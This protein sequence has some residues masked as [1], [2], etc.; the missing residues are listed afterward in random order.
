MTSEFDPEKIRLARDWKLLKQLGGEAFCFTGK[1]SETRA[2]MET[3]VEI[4]GGAVHKTVGATTTY[5][6]IPNETVT[7]SSK[8][9]AATRNGTQVIT[10]AELCSKIFPSLDELLNIN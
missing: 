7:R 10:E 1:H 6:V 2:R 9:Q 8:M 5:L 3:M 4:L